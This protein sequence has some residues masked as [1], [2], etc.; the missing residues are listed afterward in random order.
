MKHTVTVLVENRPG[1]LTHVSGLIS[2]RGFNIESIAASSTELP[3]V[4]RI[5]VVLNVVDQAE[6][7][8]IN[9]QFGKLIEVIKV[10]DMTEIDHIAREMALLKVKASEKERADI[11]NVVAIF[12][13]KIIDVHPETMVIEVT[14]EANKIDA[15]CQL[16][17]RHGI[18][19]IIRTGEIF[20]SRSPESAAHDI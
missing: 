12:R 3:D 19:E 18:V 11:T 5:S 17:E 14:G 15:F 9:D 8:Q 1:V 2:R 10:V 7:D 13:A 4:T 20:L 16:M 6:I